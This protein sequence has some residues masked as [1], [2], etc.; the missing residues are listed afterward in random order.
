M[1]EANDL[2]VTDDAT[3]KVTEV[4]KSPVPGELPELTVE[5]LEPTE[6]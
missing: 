6:E 2:L 3:L 4:H 1:V 5:S